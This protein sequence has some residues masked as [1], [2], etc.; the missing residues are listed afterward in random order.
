MTVNFRFIFIGLGVLFAGSCLFLPG[1]HQRSHAKVCSWLCPG[2]K[3]AKPAGLPGAQGR[4]M[5]VLYPTD[6]TNCVGLWR[7]LGHRY[8]TLLMTVEESTVV[9]EV[10]MPYNR[11]MNRGEAVRGTN[12]LGTAEGEHVSNVGIGQKD[13]IVMARLEAMESALGDQSVS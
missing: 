8:T 3:G 10:D 12:V 2:G 7:H 9:A 13:P 5:G 1:F 11:G 4:D 6:L